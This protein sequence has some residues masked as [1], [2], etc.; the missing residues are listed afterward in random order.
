MN[1]SVVL[2][3]SLPLIAAT[4]L[5]AQT[6]PHTIPDDLV[7]EGTT[8]LQDDTEV[9][10]DLRVT[11][12]QSSMLFGDDGVASLQTFLYSG[13]VGIFW[14]PQ[15]VAFRVGRA[16]DSEWGLP[17]AL[18]S[19]GLGYNVK[20]TGTHSVALNQS[21]TAGGGSAL[22]TGKSTMAGGDASVSMGISTQAQAFASVVLG[23]YNELLGGTHNA[24]VP[25]DTV[26]VIGNGTAWNDRGNAVTVLKNGNFG[27][28]TSAPQTPLDVVGDARFDGE[29]TITHVVPQG[30]LSMGSFTASAPQ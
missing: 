11:G 9:Q 3:I 12:P 20:P 24:W 22:A 8:E 2:T 7:V 4:S 18:Y 17:W 16:V 27:I 5:L 6:S 26:F 29:V 30:D 10:G 21:T 1:K 19:T 25:S 13:T 14:D 28:G 23:G 15:Q